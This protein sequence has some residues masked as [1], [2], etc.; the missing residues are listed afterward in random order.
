[1][2]HQA[3]EATPYHT[4]AAA[5]PQDSN[6][7]PL[8]TTDNAFPSKIGTGVLPL[9]LTNP[10]LILADPLGWHQCHE[11]CVIVGSTM[12]ATAP[13]PQA[14]G[15]HSFTQGE[16]WD[17]LALS[18]PF[19]A[20]Q[21]FTLSDPRCGSDFW[22]LRVAMRSAHH[23]HVVDQPFPRLEPTNNFKI[24]F[25]IDVNTGTLLW[26]E[27]SNEPWNEMQTLEG[28]H[29]VVHLC[30]KAFVTNPLF[31]LLELK[32]SLFSNVVTLHD[33]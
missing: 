1:M 30:P 22:P 3:A 27:N 19:H 25:S 29:L 33:M 16:Q 13:S 2:K 20:K 32:N 18:L 5:V 23:P 12:I 24:D 31:P 15:L 21:V 7:P 17:C 6:V 4:P 8:G 26:R 11:E 28:D 14:K 9:G 10:G